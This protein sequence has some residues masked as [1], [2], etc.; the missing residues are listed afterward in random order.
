M[1]KRWGLMCTNYSFASPLQILRQHRQVPQS[2]QKYQQI[3]KKLV[4]KIESI[5]KN[6]LHRFIGEIDCECRIKHITETD[7]FQAK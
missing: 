4:G 5:L 1:L 6:L 7:Y 2:G 3:E